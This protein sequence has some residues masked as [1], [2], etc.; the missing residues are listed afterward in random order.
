MGE[1][2]EFIKDLRKFLPTT[3]ELYTP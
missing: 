3:D 2:M 1:A